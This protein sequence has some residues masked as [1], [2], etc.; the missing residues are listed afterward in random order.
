MNHFIHLLDAGIMSI[1]AVRMLKITVLGGGSTYTPELINGFIERKDSLPVDEL[2][3]MDISQERL[4]IVGGFAQRMVMAAGSPF[5]VV[6]TTDL[7]EAVQ[8]A[9]YVITQLRVGQMQA[10]IEDEYLGKRHGLIGQETTGVGGMAKALRTIP[11]MME[12][13]S[14]MRGLAPRALLL[15]FTNPAGLITEAINRNAPDIKT[16]GLCNAAYTTK[17][18]L[19]KSHSQYS[20]M[21]I[22]PDRTHI[23]ALGLNHLTWYHGFTID[24]H[25]AWSNVFDSYLTEMKNNEQP[26]WDPSTLEVLGMIP[27]SYLQYYYYS[28]RKL[29]SQ[30]QW[31]PSRGE[32]VLEIEKQLL[33]EYAEPERTTPPDRLMQRGGAYYST[34]AT[35]LINSHYNDLNEEHVVNVRNG[36][37]VPDYALDWVMEMPARVGST[38]ISPIP[39][40]PLPAS[41][42]ALVASVKSF[43]LLTIEAATNGDRRA[44]HEALLAHPLGPPADQIQ[45]VLEDMLEINRDFLPQFF[46]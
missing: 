46:V 25:D 14:S 34:V 20:N 13:V 17:M 26:T 44:A 11:V 29:Q 30:N 37:A 31:P 33:Q 35:K 24:E 6:L 5:Q 40:R 19:L 1:G 27:N 3:L 39:N 21:Q 9:S 38:G 42:Y 12:I 41:C 8:D 36:G 15:N 7:N 45:M 16:V 43:E 2:C 28:N 18:H 23:K 4:D 10:R 22:D 32:Q